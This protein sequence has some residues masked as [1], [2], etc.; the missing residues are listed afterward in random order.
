M[1]LDLI[2][3]DEAGLNEELRDVLALIALELDYLP[4]L[5]VLHNI[6]IA[7]EVLLQVLKDLII[8]ELFLKPLNCC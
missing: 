8:A 2:L 3:L 6:P 7:T 4:Q 5:F 1:Y